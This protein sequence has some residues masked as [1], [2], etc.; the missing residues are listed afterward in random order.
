MKKTFLYLSQR[1]FLFINLFI[2]LYIFVNLLDGNR[3]YFS[4]VKKRDLLTNKIEQEKNIVGQ[5]ESLKLKNSMLSLPS[6]NLDFLDQLYR[7]YFVLGK[8]GEKL[9][10]VK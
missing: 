5:L 8:K 2:F 1:K 4:Y 7:S 6:L 9:Y 10:L 3:G